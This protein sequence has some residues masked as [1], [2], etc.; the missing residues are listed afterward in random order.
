MLKARIIKSEGEE[1]RLKQLIYQ[2]EREKEQ[3]FENLKIKERQILD[4]DQSI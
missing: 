3:L 4:Y 1:S 2:M